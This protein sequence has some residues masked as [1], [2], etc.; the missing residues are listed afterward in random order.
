MS[1]DPVW[2]HS[3]AEILL[4]IQV[5]SVAALSNYVL[6]SDVITDS[7]S[8]TTS[9]RLVQTLLLAALSGFVMWHLPAPGTSVFARAGLTASVVLI[10]GAAIFLRPHVWT[11]E[12][13]KA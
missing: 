2:P 4:W 6:A 5:V 9:A 7:K 10:S 13:R 12:R 3:A 1:H 8:P 11:S